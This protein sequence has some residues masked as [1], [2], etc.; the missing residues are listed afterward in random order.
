[1]RRLLLAMYPKRWRAQYGEEFAALLEDTPMTPAAVVDVLRHATGLHLRTRPKLVRVTGAALVTAAVEAMALHAGLT[2]N[3]LWAPSTPAR[4]LALAV[5][6]APGALLA[7][8]AARRRV[9]DRGH[10]AP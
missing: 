4:A 3:I 6:L 7:G 1:M 8:P 10:D 2:D 5:A 9:L